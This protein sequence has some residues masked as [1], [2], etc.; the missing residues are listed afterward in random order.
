VKIYEPQLNLY[1]RALER[2]YNRPVTERRLHFLSCGITEQL[3]S[4]DLQSAI[5]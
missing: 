4:A 3:R 1:A 5:E 2:I